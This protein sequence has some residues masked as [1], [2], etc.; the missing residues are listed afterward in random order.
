[1]RTTLV[2]SQQTYSDKLDSDFVN[3]LPKQK[4][5]IKLNNVGKLTEK[6]MWLLVYCLKAHQH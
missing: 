4:Q 1:M 5:N 2:Q 3:L 6:Y